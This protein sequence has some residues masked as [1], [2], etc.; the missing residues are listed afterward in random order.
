MKRSRIVRVSLGVVIAVVAVA[1]VAVAL[2]LRDSGPV[3]A[4]TLSHD[5]TGP[6]VRVAILGDSTDAR[7]APATEAIAYWNREL[8]RLGLRTHFDVPTIR[9][10]SLPDA[11]LRRAS[12]EAPIGVGL[13]TMRVRSALADVPADIVV[14]LSHTDLISFSVPWRAGG[15]GMAGIRRADIPPLS[16][17]NTVRNVI[18]HELG[19]VLGLRHNT[20]ATT[21]MCGR[22]AECRPAN[23]ASDTAR[24]FPLTTDDERRLRK[25]W[26]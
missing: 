7:V 21:L 12:R 20:D 9:N 14:A 24:F 5:P 25:R 1:V 16:L 17:P 8:R 4:S 11:L 19:H 6:R 13:A 15:R 22:P 10:D 3:D 26:P 23:F 18:A 2:R